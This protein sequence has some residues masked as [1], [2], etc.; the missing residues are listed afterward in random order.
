M[1]HIEQIDFH[2]EDARLPAFAIVRTHGEFVGL[3]LNVVGQGDFEVY[4]AADV[5][6]KLASALRTAARVES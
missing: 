5:A 3:S 2:D 4:F 1:E 6:L